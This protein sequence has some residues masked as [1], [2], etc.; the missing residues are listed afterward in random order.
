MAAELSPE[1]REQLL[2][3]FT[4]L[5]RNDEQKIDIKGLGFLMNKMLGQ[6]MDDMQL[7][8]ILGEVCDSDATGVS[9]DFDSFCR[10]LGPVIANASAEELNRKAFE[11]MDA[12]KSGCISR[13]ELAPLMSLAAGEK[14]SKRQVDEVLT[15]S[16]G[17]DGKVRFDDFNRAIAASAGHAS[18]KPPAPPAADPDALEM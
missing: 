3:V 18:A 17:A 6:K 9:I 13:E 8:E 5:D 11:A 7:G 4:I 2:A 1:V 14:L 16:A 12:D 15:I 10:S